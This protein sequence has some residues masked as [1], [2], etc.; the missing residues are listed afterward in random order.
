MVPSPNPIGALLHPNAAR[1]AQGPEG[2]GDFQRQRR[3]SPRPE[4]LRKLKPKTHRKV[5]PNRQEI[6]THNPQNRRKALA[7]FFC[8]HVLE[9]P[10]RLARKARSASS[11]K[12]RVST[13][14][15]ANR[16]PK[17][18]PRG[19]GILKSDFMRCQCCG[20][21]AVDAVS[22]RKKLKSPEEFL[23]PLFP[24]VCPGD[25]DCLAQ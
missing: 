5:E 4:T 19:L 12:N 15:K 18:Q 13:G 23:R 20:C 14:Q 10:A 9:Q 25:T 21:A 22:A 1:V 11:C 17:H 6:E 7:F 8:A 2:V 24:C 3:R 16:Q